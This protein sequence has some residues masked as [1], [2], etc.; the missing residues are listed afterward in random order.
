MQI[1]TQYMFYLINHFVIPY[2]S[3]AYAKLATEKVAF[4]DGCLDIPVITK[5]DSIP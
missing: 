1:K 3:K 2:F 4:Y 5:T